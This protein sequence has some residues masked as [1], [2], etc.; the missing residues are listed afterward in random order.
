MSQRLKYRKRSD[1]TVIA[2]QLALETEGFTYEKW[3]ATQTCKAGDWIVDNGGDIY[4]I[5]RDSFDRTYREVGKGTYVKTTPIWA[6]VAAEPGRVRTKEGF[7]HYRAG[8]YLVFN[9][10]HGGDAY[11]IAADRFNAMYEPAD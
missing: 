10:E 7:T 6:E 3:G 2:V 11:A 5:D 8:D 9:D 4:T 1:Q